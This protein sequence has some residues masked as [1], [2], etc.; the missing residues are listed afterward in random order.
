MASFFLPRIDKLR[1]EDRYADA[2][3]E[4]DAALKVLP[5]NPRLKAE[6]SIVSLELLSGR[7][8]PKEVQSIRADPEGWV[9]VAS[10]QS[11]SS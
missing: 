10:A 4:I 9:N 11:S 3:K 8:D 5:D 7:D 1:A 6:R 2:L